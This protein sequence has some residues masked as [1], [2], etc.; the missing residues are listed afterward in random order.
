[1]TSSDPSG[2]LALGATD[3][4]DVKGKSFTSTANGTVQAS[5]PKTVKPAV[6]D[7]W[8]GAMRWVDE[9][10]AEIAGFVAGTIVGIGVTAGC[11]A[12]TG[13]VGSVGCVV[14]GGAAGGAVGGAIT[15]L[16]KTQVTR[17]Q[18]FS[19]GALGA[20][21][22]MGGVFGAVGGFAGAG[23]GV[24]ASRLAASAASPAARAAAKAV[25][26]VVNSFVPGTAVLMADGTTQPIEDVQ[27][28]DEVLATD[29]ETRETGPRAVTALITGEG[30]KDLTTITIADHDGHE[31]G[32]LVATDGH[33]FWVPAA[34]AWVDASDLLSGDWMQTAAGTL[35][36]VTAVQHDHREQTVHNLTVADTH[37]YYVAIGADAVLV[38]NC[39][40][41][42]LVPSK[43]FEAA[44]NTALDLL[45]EIN[46][47][48]RH[49]HVGSLES[50]T[51][52]FGRVTGFTTRVD[53]VWKSFRLDFDPAK[54]P[55][56]NVQVGKGAAAQKWAV[57]WEGSEA[58]FVRILGG[59]S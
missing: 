48:T 40:E 47:A 10:Q 7:W 42:V 6:T 37:T 30:E 28:G 15:N 31:T 41:A 14:A 24:A 25:S 22:L 12:A 58:D 3:Y 51:S 45:G 13:G 57:P 9:N 50:A 39:G 29:P 38:H 46:P 26:C 59:N 56:I 19:W 21:T 55:H 5:P 17:T 49:P 52:T 4:A 1:M 16:W 8:S 2:L 18:Q 32:S 44:R 11:L 27:L 35:V 20:D 54:G 43:S 33:P 53:G 23:V 36:Q 34:G